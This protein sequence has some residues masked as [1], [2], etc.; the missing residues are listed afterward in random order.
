MT[1]IR[2]IR[3]SKGY[4][5][6]LETIERLMDAAPKSKAAD[7]L[8]VLATLVDDYERRRFPIEA[9]DPIDAIRFRMEQGG[10][11]RTNLGDLLGV[12][13][14]RVSELLSG[15]RSLTVGMIRK[16]HEA[17]EIP[18]E[19]LVGKPKKA[20]KRVTRKRGAKIAIG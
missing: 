20:K 1:R 16:L 9:P 18:L 4:R 2:P 13:S 3:N 19:S 8:E 14:G 17:W 15:K 11:S 12:G 10:H 5:A 7:T 6:A